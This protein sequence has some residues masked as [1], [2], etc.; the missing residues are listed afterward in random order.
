MDKGSEAVPWMAAWAAAAGLALLLF[1][2]MSLLLANSTAPAAL[3]ARATTAATAATPD[4]GAA[5]THEDMPQPGVSPGVAPSAPDPTATIGL[6]LSA[7]SAITALIG[8]VSSLW[9]GWRKERREV[10]Q[11]R[12]ELERTRLEVQKLRQELAVQTGAGVRDQAGR[13]DDVTPVTPGV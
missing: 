12:L 11:H 5:G 1:G 9:L 13:A 4:L 2:G 8:L 10:I 6:W 7:V 3:P